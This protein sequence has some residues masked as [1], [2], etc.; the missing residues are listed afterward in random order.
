MALKQFDHYTVRA[1]DLAASAHFYEAV[2]GLRPKPLDAFEFAMVKLWL[3]D[4]AVVHLLQAGPALD[5]F[6]G[7]S[8]PSHAAGEARRTGNFEHVAFDGDDIEGFVARLEAAGVA[9]R[10]R[11]LPNYGVEQLLFEDPDGTEIEVNF[12]A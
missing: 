2:M 4:L 5:A 7:R 6:L 3:G 12:A 10:R 11:A 8:A 9:Y 1:A